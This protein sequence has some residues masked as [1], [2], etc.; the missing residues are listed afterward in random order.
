MQAKIAG[1][2][3]RSGHRMNPTTSRVRIASWLIAATTLFLVVQFHLLPALIAGLL[4]YELVH[5]LAPKLGRI[6]TGPA[7]KRAA[8]VLLSIAIIGT[9]ISGG[10]L[11]AA[12][13]RGDGGGFAT[14]GGRLADIIERA[15]SEM[16]A[17]AV[18]SL[19]DN[20]DALKDA[21]VHWLRTHLGEL[22]LA[23]FE[24]IRSLAH[25]L[26]GLV[27]GAILALQTE[28]HPRQSG[29]LAS[30]L[31]ERAFRLAESFRQIVFAQVRISA[32]NTTFTAIY[33]AIA[34]PA[35]GVELPLTKTMIIITFV[36]GLLP[37]I[38][39][40]ISNTLIVIVSLSYSHE[41]A[42]SSL[43]FLVVIHKLEYFLN[44]RIVGGRIAARAWELLI[45]MLTMEALFG[46]A[47]LV[48]APVYYAY[49]KNELRAASMI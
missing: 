37:V 3:N 4:V 39:N 27:V 13:F 21:I 28:L 40:L 9:L 46:M 30:E 18:Q 19:P 44:A 49:L 24:A 7:A 16:P 48:A 42:F 34:L 35:A 10:L 11:L 8:L 22:Q 45:A 20:A 32:I 41:V 26:I 29:P 36:V 12:L 14:L 31:S 25:I 5:L 23:G 2:P 15:R 38:G 33:L 17:W 6:A 47:G 1:I 43:A